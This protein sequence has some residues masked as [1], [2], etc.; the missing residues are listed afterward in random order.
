MDVMSCLDNG[1]G[2]LCAFV[3]VDGWGSPCVMKWLGEENSTDLW[4][5]NGTYQGKTLF[6]SRF[7][8]AEKLFFYSLRRSIDTE[9]NS[10]VNCHYR[11]I[12]KPATVG[13]T[14]GVLKI[15]RL[16]ATVNKSIKKPRHKHPR[17]FFHCGPFMEHIT[18]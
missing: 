2:G 4:D 10:A 1:S 5:L 15:T 17:G 7:V 16:C 8:D 11:L 3:F 18:L 6:L 13:Q 9:C 14:K 12:F